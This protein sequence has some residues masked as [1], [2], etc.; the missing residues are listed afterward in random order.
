MAVTFTVPLPVQAAES[1]GPSA[2][3]PD[4][5]MPQAVEVRL[6]LGSAQ[7]TSLVSRSSSAPLHFMQLML[8]WRYS[9]L[10][11]LASWHAIDFGT[12]LVFVAGGTISIA[13]TGPSF[14]WDMDESDR[15]LVSSGLAP[16]L[17]LN[18]ETP[19]CPGWY[20]PP[21][22][23]HPIKSSLW[24]NMGTNIGTHLAVEMV[25]TGH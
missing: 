22:L 11:L 17:S 15:L 1:L 8:L 6:V 5:P 10:A 25:L 23:H 24:S 12:S 2:L 13:D 18:P 14:I 20:P 16:P 3:N 9:T 21:A 7:G 4:I 19:W